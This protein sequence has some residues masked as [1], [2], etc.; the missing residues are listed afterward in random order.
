MNP[1]RILEALACPMLR[2][3]I[4]TD[5]L[6]PVSENTRLSSKGFGDALFASWR[7]TDI[8]RRTPDP[9][10]I[11]NQAPF[12]LAKILVSGRNFGSG[13]S[14]ESAV[15]ALRDYGFE[16]IIAVSFN[17][18]FQQNCVHNGIWPLTMMQE[19]CAELAKAVLA[20]PERALRIDLERRLVVAD[21]PYA[22]SIDAYLAHLLLEGLTEDAL[23]LRYGE[24]I[25]RKLE[26]I[27][28]ED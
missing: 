14:R 1:R 7:Y 8:A 27:E 19:P 17:E 21:R 12:C 4:D 20:S 16:A 3:G 28:A 22:V 2:D 15:W 25:R 24:A 18:T 26:E 11:L 9:D 10:F 6:I 23:L 13:S 5:A